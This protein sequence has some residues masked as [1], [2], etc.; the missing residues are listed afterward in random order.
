MDGD[1]VHRVAEGF[2]A[3]LHRTQKVGIDIG[4]AI[5]TGRVH[6]AFGGLEQ[7][8]L[9]GTAHGFLVLLGVGAVAICLDTGVGTVGKGKGHCGGLC[10]R[11][12]WEK[13][14]S[15]E[16]R[17]PDAGRE[18]LGSFLSGFKYILFIPSW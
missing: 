13:R 1:V 8:V 18:H 6:A 5:L 2:A 7:S 10:E 11:T 12:A 15:E 14:S 3:G 17:T 4:D 9:S 16:Q